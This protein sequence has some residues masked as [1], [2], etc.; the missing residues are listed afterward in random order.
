MPPARA[1]RAAHGGPPSGTTHRHAQGTAQRHRPTAKATT[2]RPQPKRPAP[3]RI[4]SAA[5]RPRWGGRAGSPPGPKPRSGPAADPPDRRTKKTTKETNRAGGNT[6]PARTPPGGPP[7]AQGGT[8]GAQGRGHKPG[9]AGGAAREARPRPRAL[10]AGAG[11]RSGGRARRAADA[12]RP[13]GPLTA[14]RATARQRAGGKCAKRADG[15]TDTGRPKRSTPGGPGAHTIAGMGPPR[16][17][18]PCGTGGA[19]L[20]PRAPARRMLHCC[21]PLTRPSFT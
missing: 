21:E 12:R 5:Q 2:K 20:R 10:G 13:E 7:N 11:P 1:A 4:N 15:P 19:H 9:L 6:P 16:S 14:R 3:P 18:G 17:K 8:N